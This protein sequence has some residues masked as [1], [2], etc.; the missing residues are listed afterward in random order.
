MSNARRLY[1]RR[2]RHGRS[3]FL[4]FPHSSWF[5]VRQTLVPQERPTPF[6][7]RQVNH[8]V[9]YAQTAA[10]RV[11]WICRGQERHFDVPEHAVHFAPADDREHVRI[12]RVMRTHHYLMILISR[13]HFDHVVLRKDAGRPNVCG[14]CGGTM[15]RF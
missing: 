8:A 9:F 2:G 6:V 5:G 11:R 10:A 13:G 14:C 3:V 15:T 1:G 4:P 12:P 7:H